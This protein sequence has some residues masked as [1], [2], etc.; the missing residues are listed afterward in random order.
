MTFLMSLPAS[1]SATAALAASV[2][3][4]GG[5]GGNRD[6]AA[7]L[8]LD[9]DGDLDLVALGELGIKRGP[10]LVVDGAGE[11]QGLVEELLGPMR[12]DRSEHGHDVVGDA[13]V[14]L[15]VALDSRRLVQVLARGVHDL[16]GGRDGGVELAAVEVARGNDTHAV[17]GA[18]ELGAKALQ[19]LGVDIAG[20]GT[21]RELPHDVPGALDKAVGAGDG[22]LVPP[23]S[24]SGGA[25][26]RITR[27]MVS[28]P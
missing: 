6:A 23:K 22:L 2:I 18:E 15:V 17:E 24:F 11:V 8:A 21:V 3:V 19:G 1:W 14:E 5:V 20:D 25:M 26:K 13:E 12:A 27:R 16:H 9:L 28:A 10:G 4:V 7:D